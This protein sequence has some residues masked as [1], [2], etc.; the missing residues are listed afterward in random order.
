M[1][2]GVLYLE[3]NSPWLLMMAGDGNSPIIAKDHQMANLIYAVNWWIG[4]RGGW[5]PQLNCKIVTTQ[6][7]W[8]IFIP[9]SKRGDEDP[10]VQCKKAP[11]SNFE[12]AVNAMASYQCLNAKCISPHTGNAENAAN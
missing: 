6:Q 9:T 8:P 2:I 10:Q 7:F 5:D 3:G 1:E 12:S 11:L 4:T